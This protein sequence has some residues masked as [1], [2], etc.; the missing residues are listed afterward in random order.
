MHVRDYLPSGQFASMTGALVMS[1]GLIAAATG[2]NPLATHSSVQLVAATTIA[3]NPDWEESFAND[4]V[5]SDMATIQSTADQLSAAVKGGN[6]TDSVA[7]S[8]AIQTFALQGQGIADSANAQQEAVQ[9]ILDA[10]KQQTPTPA[11]TY[12][13]KDIAQSSNAKAD[14]RTYGN[15]LPKLFASHPS[16]S[17]AA[18]LL[19]AATYA[20]QNTAESLRGLKSIA[21][22]YR[23]LAADV[24]RLPTP[25]IFAPQAAQLAN[26][27]TAM[28]AADEEMT[29]LDSDP[30]RGLL[31]LQNFKAISNQNISI[32]L[33]LGSYLKT[34]GIVYGKSESGAVW[35]EFAVRMQAVAK[36]RSAT[37]PAVAADPNPTRS[38]IWPW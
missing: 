16:A 8:L 12:G 24:A 5:P 1:G 27:Y 29:Y 18:A 17:E 13:Q 4:S 23:A 30:V 14:L 20:D 7:K 33:Q 32:F 15:A 26:N 37:T 22:E 34:S 31:G 11:A 36:A 28:A 38:S 19:P 6:L 21:H 9:K 35:N 2:Y 25:T 10:A 3:A